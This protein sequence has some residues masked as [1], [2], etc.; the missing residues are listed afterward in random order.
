MKSNLW[1]IDDEAYGELVKSINTYSLSHNSSLDKFVNALSKLLL[2][3]DKDEFT[4]DT[5]RDTT[6]GTAVIPVIGILLK[7]ASEDEEAEFG[8]CNI[9]RISEALDEAS[10]DESVTDICLS[11]DSP[12][13]EVTGIPELARKIALI[14]DTIKPI[15]AW[16]E[17]MSCSAAYWIM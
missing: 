9:D 8:L 11:F 7:G 4:V 14:N 15:C 1:A 10:A 2:S 12:G 5:V 6:P 13:G 17:K 3:P 16:T